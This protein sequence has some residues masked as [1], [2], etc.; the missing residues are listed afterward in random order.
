VPKL[1]SWINLKDEGGSTFP[2]RTVL[3]FRYYMSLHSR[4]ATGSMGRANGRYRGLGVFV[5]YWLV[6]WRC[7]LSVK[8]VAFSR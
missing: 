5:L 3:E 7:S 2:S 1:L 8:P 4:L 6:V